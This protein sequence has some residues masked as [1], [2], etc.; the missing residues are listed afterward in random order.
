MATINLE[1][2]V[3]LA[4]YNEIIATNQL[5][6]VD[7]HATWCGPCKLIAPKLKLL[8]KELPSVVF[9]KVNVDDAPDISAPAGIRAMPTL[10]F[11]K[12]GEKVNEVVGS[13]WPKIE[14]F[15]LALAA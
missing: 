10:F 3:D 7:F 5:V 9:I 4:R 11:F 13:D 2:V 1:E 8:A 14:Q 15:A 12:D 6:V